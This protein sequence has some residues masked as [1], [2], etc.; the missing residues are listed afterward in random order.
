MMFLFPGAGHIEGMDNMSL[1]RWVDRLSWCA[2]YRHPDVFTEHLPRQCR[3]VSCSSCWRQAASDQQLPTC[4]QALA[5]V[6]K[7]QWENQAEL[8]DQ[9]EQ[10][11]RGRSKECGCRAIV[12]IYV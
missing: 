11:A 3:R 2:M 1:N 10:S 7:W 8:T 5:I 12:R 6:R 4:Q 9:K